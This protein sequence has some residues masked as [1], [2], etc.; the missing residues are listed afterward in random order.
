MSNAIEGYEV[1]FDHYTPEYG[2]DPYSVFEEL[3]SQCPVAHS[4]AY[5]GFWIL[6]RYEDVVDACHQPEVFSSRCNVVPKV[7]QG[8]EPLPPLTLGPPEHGPV[9]RFLNRWFT[10]ARARAHEPVIRHNC[11]EIIDA[12]AAAD[13]IDASQQY[14]RLVPIRM[15]CE[16]VG[17]PV[18]DDEFT[19]WMRRVY[20]SV[21]TGDMDDARAAVDSIHALFRRR[22]QEARADARPLTESDDL[23]R[24]LV[25]YESDEGV[26][27]SDDDAERCASLLVSAGID[28][29]WSTLSSSLLHLARNPADQQQLRDHPELVGSVCEEFLR[30]FSPVLV[31]RELAQDTVF[32]GA[33]MKA[34]EMVLLSTLSANR[35]ER[36]F[37]DA[38]TVSME[39]MP[40]RHIAFGV[41]IHRCLGSN[42][43]R[44]EL[45]VAVQTFLERMP[46]F[47]V[48][49]EDA[50]TFGAG[51]VWGPR[52]VPLQFDR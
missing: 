6:S 7:L 44:V 42:L 28:T 3:R 47:R 38:E 33:Q 11:N 37:P 49:D 41:G 52:T 18:D 9:K 34:G 46:P 48:A 22:V 20:Q 14:A 13:A 19:E 32:G 1:D 4:D 17:I 23:M 50:V 29:L 30:A 25:H 27:F 21:Q 45:N 39:R 16:I 31:G 8:E 2:R 36:Q 35:D 5:D 24:H 43:A 10:P 12:F 40:N 15:I 51:P 26:T